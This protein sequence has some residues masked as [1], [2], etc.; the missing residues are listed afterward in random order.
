MSLRSGGNQKLHENVRN[1][2]AV[3]GTTVPE[4]SAPGGGGAINDI[5]MEEV[6]AGSRKKQGGHLCLSPSAPLANTSCYPVSVTAAEFC[7][8]IIRSNMGRKINANQVRL[9]YRENFK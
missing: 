3:S 9:M 6:R 5:S 1:N 8:E 2:A 4:Q 7:W